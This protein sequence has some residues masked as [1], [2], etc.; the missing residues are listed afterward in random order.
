M[1]IIRRKHVIYN[2]QTVSLRCVEDTSVPDDHK[3]HFK[4]WKKKQ[5]NAMDVIAV[6]ETEESLSFYNADSTYLSFPPLSRDLMHI[7]IASTT[8][9]VIQVDPIDRSIHR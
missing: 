6:T 1:L 2:L 9:H 7:S 3:M 8:M 5:Q 4:V